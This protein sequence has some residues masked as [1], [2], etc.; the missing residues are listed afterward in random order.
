MRRFLLLLV[1]MAVTASARDKILYI[2]F[3][4][5][6]GVDIE[7]IRKA[8][9]VHVGDP[10]NDKAI[11]RAGRAVR[12]II[13]RKPE[14]GLLCCTGDGDSLLTIGVASGEHRVY[15]A[16]PQEK[17]S[18]SPELAKLVQTMDDAEKA[19]VKKGASQEDS[20]PG[21]RLARDPAAHAAELKVRDYANGHQAELLHVLKVSSSAEQ[22]AIAGDVLGYANP[23]AERNA[24]LFE[25]LRDPDSNVRDNTARAI[26]E[27]LRADPGAG[28]SFPPD[29][30]IELLR[31]GD[32]TDRN[33]AIAVLLLLTTSRDPA[34]LA[35]LKAEAWEPLMELARWHAAWNFDSRRVLARIAGIPE[36]RIIELAMGTPE[37]F[38]AAVHK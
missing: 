14:I 8:V 38:L 22:R 25:A 23:S 27:I 18:V 30:F 28:P 19:A 12:A 10:A 33:K 29:R 11:E 16:P 3:F 21:Y 37:A 24:A 15:Y 35:R 31:F 34:L 20:A 9:P 1:A 26:L 4:G 32:G 5:Y 36:D 6:E 2:E 17:V 13:G 7:A